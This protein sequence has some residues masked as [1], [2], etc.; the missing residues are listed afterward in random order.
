MLQPLSILEWKWKNIAM[1]FIVGLSKTLKGCTVIRVIVDQLTKSSH[2][3]PEK[4]TYIVDK[5]AQLYVK[6]IVRFHGVLMVIVSDRDPR[7]T[8]TFR[9]DFKKYWVLVSSST[10]PSTRK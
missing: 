4:E 9:F 1:D 3:L 7:F 5:W 6:E 10:L 2:F 8:S